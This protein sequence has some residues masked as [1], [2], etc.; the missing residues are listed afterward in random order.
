MPEQNWLN[1]QVQNGV[2]G[3]GRFAG[4]AVNTVGNGVSNAGRGVGD[5]YV[6]TPFCVMLQSFT[7]LKSLTC[8]PQQFCRNASILYPAYI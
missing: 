3:V 5:G 6:F 4:N 8:T 2:A 1:R 7:A